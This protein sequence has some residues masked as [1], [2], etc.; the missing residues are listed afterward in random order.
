M[1]ERFDIKR[2]F[3]IEYLSVNVCVCVCIIDFKNSNNILCNILHP[4]NK[5]DQYNI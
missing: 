2:S 1:V 5:N 3:K 4:F